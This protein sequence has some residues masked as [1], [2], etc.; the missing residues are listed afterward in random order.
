MNGIHDIGGMQGFGRIEQ[1]VDEPVFHEEWE[2]RTFGTMLLFLATGI[3]RIPELR[4]SVERLHA[5][6]YLETPY[7]R[8]WI[9]SVEEALNS[10]G[11]TQ[12]EDLLPHSA[13]V[14]SAKPPIEH[15]PPLPRNFVM[16]ALTAGVPSRVESQVAPRFAPGDKVTAKNIHPAGHTRLPRYVRGKKGEIARLHGSFALDDRI[17]HHLSPDPEQVYSVRF[18]ARELWG[19]SAPEKDALY[20]DLWESHLD[21]R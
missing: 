12:I 21:A 1:E 2:R 10:R 20:I 3:A 17:A 18:S 4:Y 14:G 6:C 9:H 5:Q 16:T 7:F 19:P 13:P 8:T 11:F 15:G